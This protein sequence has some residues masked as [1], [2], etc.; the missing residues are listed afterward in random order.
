MIEYPH[1]M[2]SSVRVA[3]AAWMAHV[4]GS[5]RTSACEVCSAAAS[6]REA[7]PVGVALHEEWVRI[8]HTAHAGQA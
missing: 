1:L 3:E 2:D 8:S 4:H 5:A 7:C 6:Q